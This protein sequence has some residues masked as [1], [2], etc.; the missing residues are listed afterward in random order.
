M[1]KNPLAPLSPEELKTRDNNIAHI[2]HLKEAMKKGLKKWDNIIRKEK[3]QLAQVWMKGDREKLSEWT[4]DI[5]MV[6]G[7]TKM[8]P[9]YVPT[10]K[11]EWIRAA[12]Q[13]RTA[14]LENPDKPLPQPNKPKG[15]KPVRKPVARK[16]RGKWP[17]DDNKGDNK[18]GGLQQQIVNPENQ[19]GNVMEDLEDEPL[20]PG[21]G[22]NVPENPPD[23]KPKPKGAGLKPKPKGP[24]PN[25]PVPPMP[26]STTDTTSE[27]PITWYKTGV[28]YDTK[29]TGPAA[30]PPEG[31]LNVSRKRKAGGQPKAS[32]GPSVNKRK[33]TTPAKFLT[34][35]PEPHTL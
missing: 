18:K 30:I 35:S 16:S 19:P 22:P 9:V 2:E 32:G 7:A 17:K 26:K 3:D 10:V 23:P 8:S 33:R 5:E 34:L 4:A 1:T 21:Q 24:K 27:E 14:T 29:C 11:E 12:K 15:P 25:K 31:L 13:K 20:P 28:A 6:L